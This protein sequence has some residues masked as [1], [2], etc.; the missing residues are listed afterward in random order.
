MR[1]AFAG[2]GRRASAEYAVVHVGYPS[3]VR[4]IRDDAD[5]GRLNHLV[6]RRA[7][8]RSHRRRQRNNLAEPPPTV[9]SWR[10]T[11]GARTI[12]GF[13]RDLERDRSPRGHCPTTRATRIAMDGGRVELTVTKNTDGTLRVYLKANR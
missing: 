10:R 13:S 3:A 11:N 2:C 9:T 7:E 6:H 5:P 4:Q 1:A 8:S 12:Y